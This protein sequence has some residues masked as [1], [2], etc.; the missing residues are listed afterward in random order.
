[1][2]AVYD[3][4]LFFRAAARPRLARPHFDFVHTGQVTLYLGPDVLAEI[5]DVLARPKLIAK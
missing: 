1:M 5:S 3:C 2:L 4:M